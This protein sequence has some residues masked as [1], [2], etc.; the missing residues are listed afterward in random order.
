MTT[1]LQIVDAV[2]EEHEGFTTVT[3]A[4]GDDVGAEQDAGVVFVVDA[5][6]D[7]ETGTRAESWHFATKGVAVLEFNAI[8]ALRNTE[9]CAFCGV[10]N[11]YTFYIECTIARNIAYAMAM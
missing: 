9:M 3:K 10:A 1:A 7:G 11:V 5:I 8:G 6:A 4:S 2:V